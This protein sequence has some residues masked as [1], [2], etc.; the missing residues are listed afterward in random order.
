MRILL[1]EDDHE[2][3][4]ILAI[5]LRAESYAVDT[6]AT[7][8]EAIDHLT[9]TR[10]DVACI[11]LG[12]PDGDGMHL[13]RAMCTSG[14]VQRPE[15]IIITTARDAVADRVAGLDAGAD[16]YLVKPFAFNEL[17][18]RVRALGRRDKQASAHITVADLDIDT[19]AQ[20]VH[21][22]GSPVALTAREF[23]VLRYLAHHAG[24]VIS[25]EELHEHVWDANSDPFSGSARVILSRLRRKL[26]HPSPI[27]TIT[28]AGYRLETT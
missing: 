5:G 20:T 23:A 13:I 14:Q 24:Q 15:R 6:A 21:R 22:A 11:D 17:T 9:T 19:A 10:Y 4:T 18:A 25:L 12:L 27:S 1:L 2:L 7:T 16:D 28:G 26:G 3:A 8:A